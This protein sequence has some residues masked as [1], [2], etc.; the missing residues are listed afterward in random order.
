MSFNDG[1]LDAASDPAFLFEELGPLVIPFDDFLLD[2][3][4]PASDDD[5][6]AMGFRPPRS[7]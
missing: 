5:V 4:V 7:H 2:P 1:I 6:Q 3:P